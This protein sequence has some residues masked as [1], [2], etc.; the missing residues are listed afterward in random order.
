MSGLK[1]NGVDRLKYTAE[2]KPNFFFSTIPKLYW[3]PA[4]YPKSLSVIS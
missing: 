1:S 3:I 2:G 4:P